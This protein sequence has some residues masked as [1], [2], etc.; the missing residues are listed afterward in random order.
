MKGVSSALSFTR[1][2]LERAIEQARQGETVLAGD[3]TIEAGMPAVRPL[4]LSKVVAEGAMLLRCAAQVPDPDAVLS[5]AL[6][7]LARTLEPQARGDAVKAALCQSTNRTIVHA[8]AHLLLKGA[9]YADD[10]FDC[11]LNEL[12]AIDSCNCMELLPNQLLECSWLEQLRSD[13]AADEDLLSRTCLAQPMDAF[14]SSTFDLYAFTHVIMYASDMGRRPV[15]LPRSISEIVKDAEVGLAASLDADNFDLAAELLWSWPMLNHDWS[16]TASFCFQLL[17]DVEA[18]F[19]FLP[20]PQ[21]MLGDQVAV[22]RPVESEF[23]LRTSYHATLVFGIL[24]AVA[25]LPG[26]APSR[27]EVTQPQGKQDEG[28]TLIGLLPRSRQRRWLGDW[29]QLDSVTR[30]SLADFFMSV[31]LRRSVATNDLEHMRYCIEQALILERTDMPVVHQAVAILRKVT[32]L[33][34]T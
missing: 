9:G 28:D 32:L 4:M 34:R 6:G 21:F 10:P 30:K 26:R 3:D 14:H 33:A 15:P 16:P 31:A 18:E 27:L 25:L 20:G 1:L 23:I 2:A 12:L 13:V 7:D 8:T 22:R 19:G 17:A 11:F 29:N 24:C 5:S